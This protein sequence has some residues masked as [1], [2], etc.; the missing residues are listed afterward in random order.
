[1]LLLLVLMSNC[2]GTDHARWQV[3]RSTLRIEATGSTL[4]T[5]YHVSC[6]LRFS[7]LLLHSLF[8]S[9]LMLKMW[10]HLCLLWNWT[11]MV[12][13][14]WML[15]HI[16]L[17]ILYMTVLLLLHGFF[18]VIVVACINILNIDD[19]LV[20]FIFS[21]FIGRKQITIARIDT[22]HTAASAHVDIVVDLHFFELRPG[23]L[24]TRS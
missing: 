5:N 13:L 14:A 8:L 7:V 24:A 6:T 9:H 3:T 2:F 19:I 12:T 1:M 11:H 18:D 21:V 4:G 23:L 22:H 15:C 17:R 10:M 20:F 16:L